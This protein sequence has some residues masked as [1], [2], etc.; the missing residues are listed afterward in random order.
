ML[1]L[2]LLAENRKERECEDTC[3]APLKRIVMASCPTVTIYMLMTQC[4][5]IITLSLMNVQLAQ[6]KM[7]TTW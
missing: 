3:T 7:M 1:G 4:H 6:M 2:C 5:M